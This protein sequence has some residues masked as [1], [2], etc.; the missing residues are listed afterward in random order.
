[1]ENPIAH[2]LFLVSIYLLYKMFLERRVTYSS[3]FLLFVAAI[4]RIESIYY[5]GPL[6]VLFAFYWRRKEKNLKGAK[7]AAVVFGL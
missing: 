6:L 5:I 4:A 3:A 7:L 2:G 1:M